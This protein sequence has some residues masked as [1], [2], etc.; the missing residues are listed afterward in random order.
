MTG[1][2]LQDAVTGEVE[3]VYQPYGT[4]WE[5]E[6]SEDDDVPTQAMDGDNFHHASMDEYNF[7]C[8]PYYLDPCDEHHALVKF[9]GQA[10]MNPSIVSTLPRRHNGASPLAQVWCT[11]ETTRE[12]QG[13]DDITMHEQPEELRNQSPP[14]SIYTIDADT[15]SKTLF[16]NDETTISQD[17]IDPMAGAG[18]KA[19]E[20]MIF[21]AARDAW[22]I[23]K[24]DSGSE[25]VDGEVIFD[26]RH[27]SKQEPAA[28][29]ATVGFIAKHRDKTFS[30]TEEVAAPA[31]PDRS[32]RLLGSAGGRK[33]LGKA[34]APV[35]PALMYEMPNS[36]GDTDGNGV[37]TKDVEAVEDSH[38]IEENASEAD[39]EIGYAD[40]L[41]DHHS[42]EYHTDDGSEVDQLTA[43]LTEGFEAVSDASGQQDMIAHNFLLSQEQSTESLQANAIND[44]LHWARNTLNNKTTG[45]NDD[46][47]VTSAQRLSASSENYEIS[48]RDQYR[49]VRSPSEPLAQHADDSV[50]DEELDD[51]LLMNKQDQCGSRFDQPTEILSAQS[52]MIPQDGRNIDAEK[53][54]A[55]TSETEDEYFHPWVPDAKWNDISPQNLEVAV[56]QSPISKPRPH[57]SFNVD[58]PELLPSDMNLF[59]TQISTQRNDKKTVTNSPRFSVEIEEAATRD[60]LD[61]VIQLML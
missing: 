37:D 60:K 35:P 27:G 16:D 17:K 10:H 43:E 12:L 51:K 24:Q 54:M 55:T 6:Y 15:E 32:L 18:R 50:M 45:S 25:D 13:E 46:Y 52:F 7:V 3:I 19:A 28:I 58:V 8:R 49:G 26:V 23:F 59:P 20:T 36:A 14:S 34:T 38:M 39:T 5:D 11:N 56:S 40:M 33:F 42:T 44:S 21:E 30:N 29:N 22:E 57:R 1:S 53:M 61:I 2:R 48:L 47:A 31:A 9:N 4:W 41:R